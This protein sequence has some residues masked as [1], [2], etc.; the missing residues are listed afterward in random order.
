MN[1]EEWL[2]YGWANGFCTA[3][4]CYTHDGLPTTEQEDVSFGDGDDICVHVIRLYEQQ[5]DKELVE[6]NNPAA[7]WRASS[8]G[9]K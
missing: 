2:E 6:A 3:P 8:I 5:Q 9:W 1:I 7:L 4:V